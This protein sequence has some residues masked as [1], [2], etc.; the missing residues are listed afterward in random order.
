MLMNTRTYNRF[1]GF[2]DVVEYNGPDHTTSVT[3]LLHLRRVLPKV[4]SNSAGVSR[5]SLKYEKSVVNS[6]TGVTHKVIA[7]FAMSVPADSA[8][9]TAVIEGMLADLASYLGSTDGKEVFTKNII[10]N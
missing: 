10:E 6:T 8:V 3:D 1:R 2:A 5:P 9:T 4:T 7:T